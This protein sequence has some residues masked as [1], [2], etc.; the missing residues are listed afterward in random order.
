[1][2]GQLFTKGIKIYSQNQ[3]FFS[4][5]PGISVFSQGLYVEFHIK[6][7]FGMELEI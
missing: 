1:M 5:T 4:H 6:S 3:V 7:I 2:V